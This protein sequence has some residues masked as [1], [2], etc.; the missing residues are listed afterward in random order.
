V[1]NNPSP[2]DWDQDSTSNQFATAFGQQADPL[3]QYSDT[4]HDLPDPFEYFIENVLRNRDTIEDDETIDHYRRTYSQWAAHMRAITDNRH[5]ACP[6]TQHVQRFI[7]WRR[8]VHENSRRTIKGKLA[9]L[10]QAYE[11]WQ[12][13][14][15]FPHPPDWNPFK[16]AEKETSL[17][18][19]SEKDYPDLLLSDLQSKFGTIDNIRR[20]AIIGIQLK[21]GLR[22]GEVCNLRISELHISHRE[23]QQQYPDLG[24]HPALQDHDDVIYIPA[25][26][27]GNK[28]S[29][30][31]L[32]PIDDELRWLL[33][34]HLLT[35]P[36]VDEPWVFLS[37]RTFTQLAPQ[38]ANKEWK[39]AFH[40]QYAETDE[41]VAITSHYGRHWFS[42]FWRLTE[43]ME[44]EHIQY[45][46]GD[47]VQPLDD[48]P[49]AIDDYLHPTYNLIESTYRDDIFKL[50]IALNHTPSH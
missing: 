1:T 44:R 13:K 3:A 31:R 20:R 32:I 43:G 27:D 34:R 24:S 29:N 11:Y 26:R 21:T 30:P 37:R 7:T 33:L 50:D 35:R 2:D 36:Q 28:S 6:R 9:R 38:G 40:P 16:V 5:P 48:F 17:G 23:L 14:A 45:L 47:L 15:I 10:S 22:A 19:D 42:S 39:T 8:D 41:H 25:D 49:D 12:D 46:R 18:E 4:F